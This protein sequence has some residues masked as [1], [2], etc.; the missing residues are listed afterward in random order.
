MRLR[1][2]EYFCIIKPNATII[3]SYLGVDKNHKCLSC[4][5]PFDILLN[6]YLLLCYVAM[7]IFT[8]HCKAAYMLTCIHK[9]IAIQ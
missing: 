2:R 1:R 5:F 9:Y 8:M 7:Y 3:V 6:D 4:E